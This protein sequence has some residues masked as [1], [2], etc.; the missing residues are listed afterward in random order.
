MKGFIEIKENGNRLLIPVRSI[1]G[2]AKNK[3]GKVMIA[4]ESDEILFST[5]IPEENYEQIIDK[6]ILAE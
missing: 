3:D 5:I 1:K 6:I 4:T 2:V